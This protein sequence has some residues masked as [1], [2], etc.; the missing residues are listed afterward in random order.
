[1]NEITFAKFVDL[2]EQDRLDEVQFIKD[3]WKHAKRG[4]QSGYTYWNPTE[5]EE[6][7]AL[8]ADGKNPTWEKFKN[9]VMPAIEKTKQFVSKAQQVT[10]VSAPLA[11]ALLAAGVTGGVG[12]IPMAAFLYFTRK[13]FVTPIVGVAGK[14]FDK[15]FGT[16]EDRRK[17]EEESKALAGSTVV[18]SA[19]PPENMPVT[20]KKKK[21]K[22]LA[23]EWVF[24]SD[25]NNYLLY[26]E[27]KT[28]GYISNITFN[29]WISNPNYELL[30]EGK[31][32]NWIGRKIGQG[33]GFVSGFFDNIQNKI[34][35]VVE[36]SLK[37]LG[38]FAK[39]N[40]IGIVKA[41]FLMALGVA[42]GHGVTKLTNSVIQQVQDSAH[43]AVTGQ[44]H[45]SA[46]PE[47]QAQPTE[48]PATASTAQDH[49]PKN[50]DLYFA[51]KEFV[52]I[53]QDI[54]NNH[55]L[56]PQEMQQEL[57]KAFIDTHKDV[58]MFKTPLNKRIGLLD[59][60]ARMASV[61][62]TIDKFGTDI[63]GGYKSLT[64]TPSSPLAQQTG[65]ARSIPLLPD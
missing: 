51:D 56:S 35:A 43:H 41:A 62:P 24:C 60:R 33:V 37:A 40:R 55:N 9:A 17:K 50:A 11:A 5:T 15:V 16:D 7:K 65:A 2:C 31:I 53:K 58:D 18:S 32:L 23:T 38:N 22:V 54:L 49:L 12:A 45:S 42:I 4:Y 44:S 25:Y 27:I 6:D 28:L 26:N 1:M 19:Q 47:T 20:R 48:T 30:N 3:M 63:G 57:K 52:R 59:I 29:E 64:L 8:T 10:G 13:I 21:K 36:G 14:G 46:T 61:L 39:D 34:E